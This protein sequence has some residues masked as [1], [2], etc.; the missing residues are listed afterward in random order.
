MTCMFIMNMRWL[1][2]IHI[3]SNMMFM[4]N[5]RFCFLSVQMFSMLMISVVMLMIH[6][7]K[8]PTKFVCMNA[9][10]LYNSVNPL[11]DFGK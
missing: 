8:I 2:I 10:M 1:C 4:C 7:I 9:R 3:M 6:Y 5:R 11:Q